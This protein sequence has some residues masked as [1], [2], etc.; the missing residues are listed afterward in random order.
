M[1][2]SSRRDDSSLG[3]EKDL[4]RPLDS[5]RQFHVLHQ[6]QGWNPAHEGEYLGA[7]KLRLISESDTYKPGTQVIEKRNDL[8]F[9]PRPFELHPHGP[10]GCIRTAI[11]GMNHPSGSSRKKTAVRVENQDN[12][13]VNLLHRF[14][15]LS[16]PPP[17]TGNNRGAEPRGLPAGMVQGTSIR[18]EYLGYGWLSHD[19]LDTIPDVPFLIQ[20][21]D[22]DG[23]ALYPVKR[24][25]LH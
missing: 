11:Q 24:S 2:P 8:V 3:Q 1:F 16:S 10:S 25:L 22:N 9:S 12:I 23:E 17:L 14:R 21:R 13:S 4:A 15:D 6:R 18:H 5:E 20:G 7:E 19:G